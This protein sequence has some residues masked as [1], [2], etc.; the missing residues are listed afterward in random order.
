VDDFSVRK[1]W[2]PPRAS[3]KAYPPHQIAFILSASPLIERVI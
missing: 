3:E 2:R 1:A